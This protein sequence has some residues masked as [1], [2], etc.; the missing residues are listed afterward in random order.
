M[1]LTRHEKN[2]H[3]RI[4]AVSV[5][6]PVYNTSSYL[7][8]C[9]SSIESQSLDNL[10]IICVNDGSTDNSLDILNKHAQHDSRYRIINQ[11]NAGYG[12][13][14]N[15]GLAVATG[16]Y[17]G[18]VEPDDFA[19]RSMFRSLYRFASKHGCDVVKS[20][21]YEHEGGKSSKVEA[22]KGFSYKRV[23]NPRDNK[24][25]LKVLPIIWAGIYRREMIERKGIR[26]NETPG[27][28]FQDTSFVFKAWVAAD[29]AAL[30]P[31]AFLH[32]RIDNEASSV[33][34]AKKVFAV[35]DEFEASKR[36]LEDNPEYLADYSALLNV[37]RFNA[38]RWNYNRIGEDYR[39]AFAQRWSAELIS[40]QEEGTL[41]RSM[42]NDFDW[43]AIEHL[44]RDYASFA[45]EHRER[46]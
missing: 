13:A 39:E 21:Y 43:N 30:L 37:L 16:E 20:N 14:M 11:S 17:L 18:I 24:D 32:Y 35:C 33:K 6:V 28:S 34:D 41:A 4:P 22:F 2:D 31:R 27:A 15:A 45:H 25:V 1:R 10:E 3:R 40:A 29:R 23:F 38:Y 26:F 36:F 46:F 19:S 44:M 5:I 42:F 8:L 12:A 7:E 9:L